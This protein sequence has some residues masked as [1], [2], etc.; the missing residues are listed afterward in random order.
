L[1]LNVAAQEAADESHL[2]VYKEILK[3]RNSNVWR[4]GAYESK[5]LNND[6][7]VGFTR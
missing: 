3:L 2:K 4:Y 5:A 7:V 1:T 6:K